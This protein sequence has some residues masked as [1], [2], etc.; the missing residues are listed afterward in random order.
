MGSTK[1]SPDLSSPLGLGSA[2]TQLGADFTRDSI[3]INL[4]WNS[5]KYFDKAWHFIFRLSG[6]QFL[7]FLRF[8]VKKE[9][10]QTFT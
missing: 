6:F 2:S 1:P 8:D 3:K 5:I 9:D 7:S 4:H 10:L